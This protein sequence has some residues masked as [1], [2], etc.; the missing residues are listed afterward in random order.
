MKCKWYT[1]VY[2]ECQMFPLHL[3]SNGPLT[4]VGKKKKEK[5]RKPF[6]VKIGDNRHLRSEKELYISDA[7]RCCLPKALKDFKIGSNT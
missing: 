4:A 3:T 7:L 6:C 2:M 5:K 1:C